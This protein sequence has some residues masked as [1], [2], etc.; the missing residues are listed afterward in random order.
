MRI[1]LVIAVCCVLAGCQTPAPMANEVLAS[2]GLESPRRELSGW[3]YTAQSGWVREEPASSA[4]VAEYTL[5]SSEGSEQ[6]A[7]LVVYYFGSAG[8]GTVQ[9]NLD[10]WIG[11]FE[12]PDGS[13]S[14]DAAMIR[15]I[16]TLDT[17][18]L[19]VTTV[20][21]SGRYVA[22]IFPGSDERVNNP[23]YRLLAAIVT[24]EAGP[25]YVKLIGPEATVARWQSSFDGFIG[26]LRPTP[27]DIDGVDAEHP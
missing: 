14:S 8:A 4:R 1:T 22:Q 5:P 10:R 24:T 6:D 26:S 21:L 19:A 13:A 16:S 9:A 3:S 27:V 11:Q 15:M 25:Y 18:G 23:G 12:Q 17:Q 20:D 2:A 7:T